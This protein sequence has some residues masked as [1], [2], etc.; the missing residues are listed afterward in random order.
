MSTC[1]SVIWNVMQFIVKSFVG[2]YIDIEHSSS[3]RNQG[4][5]L[6]S[7]HSNVAVPVCTGVPAGTGAP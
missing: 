4:L 7:V 5:Q 1:G 3:S 6:S 2:Y